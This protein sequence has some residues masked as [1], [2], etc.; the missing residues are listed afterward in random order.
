MSVSSPFLPPPPHHLLQGAALFLDFDGTLVELAPTPDA[1]RVHDRLI[2]LL[3]L[4]SERLQGRLAIISG[5]PVAGIREFLPLRLAAVGSHGMEFGAADGAIEVPDRPAALDDT[6][7]AMTELSERTP[8][9]LVED[10]PLGAVLHY[11][12]APDAEAACMELATALANEHGLHV[13]RGKM[14]VEVR[15][16]GGDKGRAIERLMREPEL[17]DAR[18]IFMGD[19][20]TDEPG[21]A[22]AARLGGAGV[23]VGPPR[24]TEATYHLEGVAQTLA[25]LETAAAEI[26]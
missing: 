5:R 1:V 17:R 16:P 25:W 7:A 9:T 13:E 22:A 3:S 15:A 20:F 18:P 4:L 24:S 6:L 11:R 12:L 19:D 2:N 10:K 21:F 14:M 8:G 26:E 23:L